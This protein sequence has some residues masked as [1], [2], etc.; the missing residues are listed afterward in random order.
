MEDETGRLAG[1]ILALEMFD[2]V[3]ADLLAQ[4]ESLVQR[5]VLHRVRN[6]T[7]AQFGEL[8]Q[9][10]LVVF[11]QPR[12]LLLELDVHQRVGGVE[13]QLQASLSMPVL[14]SSDGSSFLATLG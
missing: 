6:I 3:G 12:R 13:V 2:Q 7:R 1:E 11:P 14:K 4:G 10:G 8:S 5:L 9:L